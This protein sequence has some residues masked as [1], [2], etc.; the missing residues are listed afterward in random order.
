VV[1]FGLFEFLHFM[2]VRHAVW[3]GATVVATGAVDGDYVAAEQ[4]AGE[5]QVAELFARL[6]R[7]CRGA[8]VISL[9]RSKRQYL[10]I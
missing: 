9:G 5:V 2:Q 1:V 7:R 8:Q 3:P 4:T 10:L 6:S